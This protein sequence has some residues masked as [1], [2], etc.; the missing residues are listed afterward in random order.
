MNNERISGLYTQ[1]RGPFNANQSY[2]IPNNYLIDRIA[3]HLAH[4]IPLEHDLKNATVEEISQ[5][6]PITVAKEIKKVLDNN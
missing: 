4:P 6:V 5:Y 1:I 3:I 2:S